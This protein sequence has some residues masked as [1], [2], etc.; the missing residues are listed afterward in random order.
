MKG[1]W[2]SLNLI[3]FSQ[4]V[5]AASLVEGHKLLVAKSNQEFP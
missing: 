5:K 4:M 3:S 1:V 2:L